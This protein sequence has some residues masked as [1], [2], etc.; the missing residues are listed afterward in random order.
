VLD[1]LTK[2]DIASDGT[3][4]KG[5]GVEDQPEDDF[6]C[7]N[8]PPASLAFDLNSLNISQIPG[9]VMKRRRD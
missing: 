6:F 7:G 3:Q 1:E 8:E 5:D 4:S 2:K 9:K